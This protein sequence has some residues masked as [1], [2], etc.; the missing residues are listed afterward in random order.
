MST[1]IAIIGVGCRFPGADDAAAFWRLLRDG[2]DAISTID[3]GRWPMSAFLAAG[4]TECRWAGLVAAGD[5]YDRGLFGLSD[6]EIERMDPQQGMALELAWQALEQAAIDPARLAGSD[7]GVFLGIGTRDYD[8]RAANQWEQLDYRTSTGAS[9]AVI[10]NRLSYCLGLTGPSLAI[11]NACAASLAAVHLACQSLRLGECSV[12]L[13]GGVQLI[14][15]PANILAFS[16]AKLLARDGRCKSFSE[17]ADGYVCGEGGG[18]LVLKT[19]E[20]A[21]AAGD[22]VW[23]VIRGSA[24]NHNGQSNGLSAPLGRAQ[25]A[26]I[27]QALRQAEVEPAS[28]GY[29]EAHA[30]GTALGDAI[31]V[32]A[33]KSVFGAS[34]ADGVPCLIGSVKSNIGHLEAAAGIAGLVKTVLALAHAEVPAS[35]HSEPPNRHLKLEQGPLTVARHTQPWPAL[36]GPR[37][38]GVSA[39]GFGGANAHLV[40]EQAPEPTAGERGQ[41]PQPL[42]L[43]LAAASPTALRRLAAQWLMLLAED[44]RRDPD[45][46]AD[47]CFSAA[48]G[49]AALRHRLALCVSHADQAAVALE[50]YLD[51]QTDPRLYHDASTPACL[52]LPAREH[53][54]ALATALP[55]FWRQPLQHWLDAARGGIE[56]ADTAWVALG[57]LCESWGLPVLAVAGGGSAQA[58]FA[59]RLGQRL[60]AL[61]PER[62]R[63]VVALHLDLTQRETDGPALL[64]GPPAATAG[65]WW[66]DLPVAARDAATLVR[67]LANLLAAAY[68]GGASLDWAAFYRPWPGHRL[69]LPTYP[70]ERSRHYRIPGQERWPGTTPILPLCGDSP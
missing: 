49:R 38:A 60:A 11:D 21:Q 68:V 56:P 53:L 25:Q 20:Q 45:W 41:P 50:R 1:P 59:D 15:S 18:V 61:A 58:A 46:F 32:G 30:S 19:L 39:F 33:L 35:L 54:P 65:H 64:F 69:L 22:P 10:A 48:T 2:V 14:L 7:C 36:S 63:P 47:L 8:R 29:I 3:D 12:A 67:Q 16:Q 42:L 24:L 34:R 28:I 9:G 13:A 6:Q 52:P 40:L 70:F 17:R 43:P 62:R 57:A 66:S 27:R 37:R 26:L 5:C 23:A 55:P 51:G 31:E 4:S 44:N